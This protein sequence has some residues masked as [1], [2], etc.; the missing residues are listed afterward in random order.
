MAFFFSIFIVQFLFSFLI[1]FVFFSLFKK[2][3]WSVPILSLLL[4]GLFLVSSINNYGTG[5]FS[6]R[7]HLFFSNDASMILIPVILTFIFNTILTL[8]FYIY[9]WLTKK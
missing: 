8:F 1:V 3:L 4:L 6:E 5:S 9:I 2:Y 7:Y